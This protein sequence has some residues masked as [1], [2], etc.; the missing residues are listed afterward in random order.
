MP[1]S[2]VNN[3]HYFRA[4]ACLPE[5]DCPQRHHFTPTEQI[6]RTLFGQAR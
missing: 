6:D 1:I 3:Y 2:L 5:V 4:H